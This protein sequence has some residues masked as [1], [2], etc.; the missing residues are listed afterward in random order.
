MKIRLSFV[1]NSSS[2]SFTCSVCEKQF[3]GW[4]C[5]PGSDNGHSECV[6]GHVF[7][8]DYEVSVPNPC[9][10]CEKV[11]RN[12]GNCK[13]CN[14]DGVPTYHRCPVCTFAVLAPGEASLYLEKEYGVSRADAFA[15]VR[16]NNPRR[17]KLHDG[18]Y[19]AYVCETK[20]ITNESILA[21][22]KDRFGTYEKFMEYMG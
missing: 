7:C 4:D 14:W 12:C 13:H 3:T 10:T 21:E 22:M 18:E 11:E 20:G 16:K 1:S 19:L 15:Q 5:Y 6:N 8:D 2:S 17:R 9:D